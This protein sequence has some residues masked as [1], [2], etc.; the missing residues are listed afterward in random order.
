[1]H[2]LFL[3]EANH[4]KIM[5]AYPINL[6]QTIDHYSNRIYQYQYLANL[7][8]ETISLITMNTYLVNPFQSHVR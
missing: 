4:F 6:F 1:M 7:L 2:C 8:T 3:R 5:I